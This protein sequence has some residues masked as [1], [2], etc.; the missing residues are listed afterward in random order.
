MGPYYDTAVEIHHEHLRQAED[1]RVRRLS[2]RAPSGVPPRGARRPV[3][4]AAWAGVII[5][6]VVMA[7]QIV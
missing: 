1:N 7:G 5:G 2:N 6:V 4:I 3:A